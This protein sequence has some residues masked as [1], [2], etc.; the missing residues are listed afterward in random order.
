MATGTVTPRQAVYAH[1]RADPD[2]TA[3]VADRIY[4]QTPDPGATY[5]LLVLNTISNVDVRDLAGVA[6]TETRLQVTAMAS[7]LK[8]AE[9]IALAVR[10][11]LEGVSGL[12]AGALSVIACRVATYEPIYQDEVGQTH[13]HVD[14]ILMHKGGI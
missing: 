6:Y 14:V 4:H 2:V 1:L 7:T 10:R 11:S 13:Y 12:M 8:D 9:S 3:L 5:P